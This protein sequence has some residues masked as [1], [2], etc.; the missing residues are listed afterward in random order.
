[1]RRVDTRSLAVRLRRDRD[2]DRT[3][4][5]ETIKLIYRADYQLDASAWPGGYQVI[6]LT[7]GD[8]DVL[9]ATCAATEI[10]EWANGEY[11]H[12]DRSPVIVQTGHAEGPPEY[13]AGCN[14]MIYSDYGDPDELETPCLDCG[15]L[16]RP[17][18]QEHTDSDCAGYARAVYDRRVSDAEW[19][20]F[21][22]RHFR[23]NAA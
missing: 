5:Q 16:L 1:M 12:E 11:F 18:S 8:C 21:L 22:Y 20:L 10:R 4:R 15:E 2:M 19:R 13:C 9:C 23:G 14:V 7:R 6:Y 17:E 3:M